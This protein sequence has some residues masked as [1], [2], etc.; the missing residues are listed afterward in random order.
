MKLRDFTLTTNELP[1]TNVY[2]LGYWEGEPAPYTVVYRDADG[3]WWAH[4]DEDDYI[5]PTSWSHLPG[6]I[7]LNRVDF[8]GKFEIDLD[9]EV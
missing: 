8:H 4:D 7:D 3:I 6:G 2:V 5:A 1:P 9:A